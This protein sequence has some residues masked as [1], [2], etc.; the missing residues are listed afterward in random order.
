MLAHTFTTLQ[1]LQFVQSEFSPLPFVSIYFM[2]PMCV[3]SEIEYMYSAG[4][5]YVCLNVIWCFITYYCYIS[6]LVRAV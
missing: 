2:I 5:N 1:K 6:Q 3:N 4:K